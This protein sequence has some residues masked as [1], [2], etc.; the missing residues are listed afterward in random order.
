MTSG[1]LRVSLGLNS[2]GKGG[3]PL[4]VAVVQ[5]PTGAAL[6]QAAT[7]K[8]RLK[9]KEVAS[10]RFFV[11]KTGD[12][13]ARDS[14]DIRPSVA[15]GALVVVAFGDEPFAGVRVN[16]KSRA[17]TSEHG[18]DGTDA[19]S[20]PPPLT[21]FRI[22]AAELADLVTANGL[23]GADDSGVQY[24]SLEALWAAQARQRA[25]YYEA[26]DSW[27]GDSGYGGSTDEAAMIGDDGS[28]ADVR[29]ARRD[30]NLRSRFPIRSRARLVHDRH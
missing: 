10:A 23:H 4:A 16:P 8:L 1:R 29:R 25:A 20:T 11:W 2:G 21:E 27:W 9:K 26:N 14:A 15:D 18:K 12:E 3:K 24:P 30:P 7:N 28:A 22:R 19:T 17:G 6:L 5:E 13:I